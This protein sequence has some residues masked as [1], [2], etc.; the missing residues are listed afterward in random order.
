MMSQGLAIAIKD[1]KTE[2]RTKEMIFSMLV[3]SLFVMVAFYF[4]FYF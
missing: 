4:A 2:F 3:F 1:I